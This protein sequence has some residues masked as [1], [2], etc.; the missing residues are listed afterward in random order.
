MPFGRDNAGNDPAPRCRHRA[1]HRK[2]AIAQAADQRAEVLLAWPGFIDVIGAGREGSRPRPDP[3]GETIG[4]RDL[5]YACADRRGEGKS[6]GAQAQHRHRTE[7]I[8]IR[9]NR[10]EAGFGR[11]Q[12]PIHRRLD[13]RDRTATWAVLRIDIA[14]AASGRE[15][16]FGHL[17]A[18]RARA[19]QSGVVPL[20]R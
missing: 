1:A 10:D 16:R 2:R 4:A 9:A 6:A 15:N 17:H 14:E 18:E 19:K 12:R 20:C 7:R 3:V 5:G 8:G 13:C 11:W